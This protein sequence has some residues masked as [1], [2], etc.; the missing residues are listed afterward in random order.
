LVVYVVRLFVVV[1]H[2]YLRCTLRLRCVVVTLYVV[3]ALPLNLLPLRCTRC[4]LFGST[5]FGC[6]F[7]YFTY[8]YVV[9]AVTLPL[10]TRYRCWLRFT[11][12]V[13]THFTFAHIYTTFTFIWVGYVYC[14]TFVVRFVRCWLLRFTYVPAVTRCAVYIDLRCVTWLLYGLRRGGSFC[15]AFTRLLHLPF[16][17]TRF[18]LVTL[19]VGYTTF[20]GF[21]LFYIYLFGCYVVVLGCFPVRTLPRCC[22]RTR[23]PHFRL[24]YVLVAITYVTLLYLFTHCTLHIYVTLLVALLRLYLGCAISHTVVVVPLV[25][26]RLVAVYHIRPGC[27]LYV[28]GYVCYVYAF[29]RYYITLRTVYVWL[30]VVGWFYRTHTPHVAFVHTYAL[31]CYA[32]LF[33]PLR[34]RLRCCSFT[35]LRVVVHTFTVRCFLRFLRFISLLHLRLFRFTFYT[36]HTCRLFTILRYTVT[37]LRFT[38]SLVRV[39]HVVYVTF[40]G[41]VLRLR[42]CLPLRTFGLRTR[43][44]LRR[45]ARSLFTV[46]PSHF[47]V[48]LVTVARLHLFCVFIWLH[49]TRLFTFAVCVLLPHAVVC[50]TFTFVR[51]YVTL[52]AL[53]IA[54]IYILVGTFSTHGLFTLGSRCT[55]Y[56]CAGYVC[57]CCLRWLRYV[58]YRLRCLR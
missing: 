41:L 53:F 10:P 1:I 57:V 24:L 27:S 14:F 46:A 39:A 47:T 30:P 49:F 54:Y 20:T 56:G 11:F 36:T 43:A 8:I 4:Y 9:I 19:L 15:V 25:T 22:L 7:G 44:R 31:R 51:C 21:T 37:F 55:H 32:I 5:P 26:L 40:A 48:A 28:Y 29:G 58:R 23:L 50:Y 18:L 42:C 13:I 38:R 45:F 35:T 52:F 17:G 12:V 34:C 33:A 16:T 6:Y 2:I 3:V